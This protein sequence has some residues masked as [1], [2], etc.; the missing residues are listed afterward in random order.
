VRIAV[1]GAAGFIGSA[2][3][4]VA[5]ERGHEI[6]P[7][8][9]AHGLDILSD[10]APRHVKGCDALLHLAGVLGTS[11]LF[12]EIDT[13]IDV[14]IKGT[15]RML[16]AA[17]EADAAFV[18]ITMPDCWPSSIYQATKLAGKRIAHAYHDAVGLRVTQCRTFNVYG[19]GQAV[20][21]GHPQKIIPTFASRSWARQPMPIWGTGAN[22]VDLVHVDDV[23]AS[24]VRACEG[25]AR[26]ED[27]FGNC[28]EWDIGT[29]HQMTVLDVAHAVSDVTGCGL[30]EFLP[31]RLGETHDTF[32]A[33][34]Q[35]GPLLRG[36]RV[37]DDVE[38]FRSAVEHYRPVA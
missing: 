24:L 33:A 30:V 18:G 4:R 11:E 35:F 13:A 7:I 29:G 21:P 17:H 34:T 36:K 10:D 20:G 31:M 22:T 14:N 5:A 9:R 26:G 12:D 27:E 15:R 8:D 16:H 19:P 1:T 37:A 28:D 23:A 6:V 38:R 3:G 25:T 32:L 2:V